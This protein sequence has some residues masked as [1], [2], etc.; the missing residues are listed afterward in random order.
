M[1]LWF[2]S[3]VILDRGHAGGR[4]GYPFRFRLLSPAAHRSPKY[5]FAA[6]NVTGQVAELQSVSRG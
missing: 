1:P 3:D 5:Y 4:P 2:Y 6:L